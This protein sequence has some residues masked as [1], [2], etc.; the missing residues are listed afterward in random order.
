MLHRG[1]LMLIS[2]LL[3]HV[4]YV[5]SM[6]DIRSQR[7]LKAQLESMEQAAKRKQELV[8]EEKLRQQRNNQKEMERQRRR[9]QR[10]EVLSFL[11]GLQSDY[12]CLTFELYMY[13]KHSCTPLH[14]VCSW[15]RSMNLLP[16]ILSINS[17]ITSAP[18]TQ[19]WWQLSWIH[20]YFCFCICKFPCAGLLV[21]PSTNPTPSSLLSPAL[22]S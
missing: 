21:S 15:S 4:Q 10:Q 16:Y 3:Q 12:I 19:I 6:N 14:C 20:H 17:I 13:L 18:Y 7:S 11:S 1:L 2:V 8:K 9:R 5:P 22:L